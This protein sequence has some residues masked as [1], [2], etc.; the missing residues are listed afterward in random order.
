MVQRL[1]KCLGQLRSDLDLIEERLF[2]VQ[3]GIDLPVARPRAGAKGIPEEVGLANP[4]GADGGIVDELAKELVAVLEG[5]LVVSGLDRL[6]LCMDWGGV[7][8]R[9]QGAV[10]RAG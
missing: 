6:R 10:T 3:F 4:A 1:L 5:L 9:R 8:G 2:G 7:Q